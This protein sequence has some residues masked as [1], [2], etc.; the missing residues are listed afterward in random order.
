MPLVNLHR[1]SEWATLQTDSV[2][3]A[4]YLLQFI[5]SSLHFEIMPSFPAPTL[6]AFV[7]DSE[8]AGT[9]FPFNVFMAPIHIKHGRNF[10]SLTATKVDHPQ[11]LP[12]PLPPAKFSIYCFNL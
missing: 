11:A 2:S 12:T 1:H 9:N 4:K 6:S 8:S 10:E 3:N 7:T 5:F